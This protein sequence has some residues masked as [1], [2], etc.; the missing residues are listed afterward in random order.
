MYTKNIKNNPKQYLF[1]YIG[2]PLNVCMGIFD[3]DGNWVN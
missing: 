1:R 3:K 2:N